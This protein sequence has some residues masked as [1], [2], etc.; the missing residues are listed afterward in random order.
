MGTDGIADMFGVPD[1]M[2][3]DDSFFPYADFSATFD[4]TSS[5]QCPSSTMSSPVDPFLIWDAPEPK[6][7][8]PLPQSSLTTL[9]LPAQAPPLNPEV[10]QGET[11]STRYNGLS[12]SLTV[13][14][15]LKSRKGRAI[16]VLGEM[17]NCDVLNVDS[18]ESGYYSTFLLLFYLWRRTNLIAV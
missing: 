2:F 16:T 6:F 5:S 7:S 13:V 4:G 8:T 14:V 9:D 11:K 17:G 1:D 18:G 3:F 15:P 12:A 10:T